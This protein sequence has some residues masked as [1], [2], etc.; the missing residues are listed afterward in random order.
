MRSL[1]RNKQLVHYANPMESE[2]II[3][4][5]G[6]ETGEFST[7][8]G[9][10]KELRINIS[11][12]QGENSTR[13]FGDMADYDRTL[14]TT[15]MNLPISEETVLWIDEKNTAKPY[16]YIVKKVA[17]SINGVTYAVKKVKVSAGGQNNN[18][19]AVGS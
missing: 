6:N 3:D 11:A 5:W 10:P 8:Y 2:P 4:E 1:N 16:D 18:N 12:A 19:A 15:E 17:P 14:V 7:G 9:E 13:E